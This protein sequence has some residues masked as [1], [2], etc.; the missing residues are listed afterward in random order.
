M[1]P[2]VQP[3]NVNED[4]HITDDSSFH[5]YSKLLEMVYNKSYKIVPV[6][7]V[8]L[9]SLFYRSDEKFISKSNLLE[10]AKQCNMDDESLDNFC[11][12][13]TSFGNIFDL[14]LIDPKYKYVIVKPI[15]FLKS[16]NTLLSP[17]DKLHQEHPLLK[18]G[19]V[20]ESALQNLFCERW[21]A[22]IEALILLNLATKIENDSIEDLDSS[23]NDSNY[24]V[25]LCHRSADDRQPLYVDPSSVYLVTTLDTPH[26]QKQA[27]FVQQLLHSIPGSKLVKH[28]DKITVAVKVAAQDQSCADNTITM[29]S[30]NPFTQFKISDASNNEACF[31]I[32]EAIHHIIHEKNREGEVKYMYIIPCATE[33]GNQIPIKS[34]MSKATCHVLSGD[35]HCERRHEAGK[36][37]PSW[38]EALKMKQFSI[39]K[40]CSTEKAIKSSELVFIAEQL[41]GKNCDKEKVA[42]VFEF[43]HNPDDP[44]LQPQFP[45]DVLFTDILITWFK[46]YRSEA[47]LRYNLARKIIQLH[48]HHPNIGIAFFQDL[49]AEI[50]GA[51][52]KQL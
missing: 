39:P 34:L 43:H 3:I 32:V 5:L 16:L 1:E 44:V 28:T 23:N 22:F 46:S 2:S 10:K 48:E 24:F 47:E 29:I 50:Y 42:E 6:S 30:S 20:S 26:V 11:K 14:T 27:L 37:N 4:G 35:M 45:K 51:M 12:F 52:P 13:Y 21:D 36:I 8:F 9:R 31:K 33:T 25:P 18:Y 17:T 49:A 15:G 40:E 19:I 7:W 41:S 38:H